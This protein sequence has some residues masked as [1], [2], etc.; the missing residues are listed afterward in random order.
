MNVLKYRNLGEMETKE[1][2][3]KK[4]W[5][6]NCNA[7]CGGNGVVLKKASQPYST[8]FFELFFDDNFLRTEADNIEEAE[9]KAFDKFTIMKNCVHKYS[10]S[11]RDGICDLCGYKTIK[12]Y[13]PSSQCSTCGKNHSNLTFKDENYCIT[14]Y[15]EATKHVSLPKNNDDEQKLKQDIFDNIVSERKKKYGDFFSLLIGNDKINSVNDISTDGS[16]YQMKIIDIKNILLVREIA[17][18][19]KESLF[20]FN[21]E[22]YKIVDAIDESNKKIKYHTFKQ[23][24]SLLRNKYPDIKR[25]FYDKNESDLSDIEDQIKRY[26]LASNVAKKISVDLDLFFVKMTGDLHQSFLLKLDESINSLIEKDKKSKKNNLKN[27][28]KI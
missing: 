6:D 26:S 17:L 1:Y 25:N 2:H 15:Y 4:N 18:I 8:A 21:F 11:G 7:Q 12:A 20:G 24:D 10:I 28:P 3:C 14:D 5:P 9:A 23:L 19:A 27:K 22:D 16:L 13:P